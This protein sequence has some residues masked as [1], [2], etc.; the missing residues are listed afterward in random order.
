[1]KPESRLPAE[2]WLAY[3]SDLGL[4]SFYLDRSAAIGLSMKASPPLAM[5]AAA[6]ASQSRRPMQSSAPSGAPL[7]PAP[8][9]LPVIKSASLF[10]ASER[11]VND[12]LERIRADIGD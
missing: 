7:R 4:T 11:V 6:A 10:E 12:S 3:F 1:M 9:L 5:A 8:P 2:S